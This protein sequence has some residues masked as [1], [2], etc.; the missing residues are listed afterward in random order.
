MTL[1][2]ESFI[3]AHGFLG[4]ALQGLVPLSPPLWRDVRVKVTV[5]Q[6]GHQARLPGL[7]FVAGVTEECFHPSSAS[8]RVNLILLIPP[9]PQ[10]M[11]RGGP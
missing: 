2:I 9:L 7:F 10:M 1:Y 4:L 8:A 6:N 3:P 11:G 5:M